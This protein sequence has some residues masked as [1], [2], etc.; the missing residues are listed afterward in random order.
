M[1]AVWIAFI[2]GLFIGTFLGVF[3]MCLMIIA[4]RSDAEMEN[5]YK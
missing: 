1:E 4:K 3:I 2:V 5:I